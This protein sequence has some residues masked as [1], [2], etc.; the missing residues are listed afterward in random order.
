MEAS[1]CPVGQVSYYPFE[2]PKRSLKKT[3]SKLPELRHCP[4]VVV[5][6]LQAPPKRRLGLQN[7]RKVLRHRLT[8]RTRPCG[9]VT[10]CNVQVAWITPLVDG[11]TSMPE[12]VQK[13]SQQRMEP[14]MKEPLPALPTK[15]LHFGSLVAP[16]D[17]RQRIGFPKTPKD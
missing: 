10:P 11:A 1:R 16:L 12:Y 7:L 15:V 5:Q 17:A 9:R 2:Q 4:P 3:H 14:R 13:C 8:R 6:P